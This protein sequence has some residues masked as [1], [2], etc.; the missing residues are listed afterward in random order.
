MNKCLNCG[1]EFEAPRSLNR[2]FCSK[3]CYLKALQT[4]SEFKKYF[5]K[6]IKDG[7]AKNKKK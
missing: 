4:D 2:K 5:V 3:E 7:L 6:K 1:K